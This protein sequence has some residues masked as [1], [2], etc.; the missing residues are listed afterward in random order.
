MQGK[1]PT[2]NQRKSLEASKLDT[3]KWLV[4]KENK[5]SLQVTNVDTGEIK[6]ISKV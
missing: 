6:T 4:L 2:R 5:D 3:Y 1:K